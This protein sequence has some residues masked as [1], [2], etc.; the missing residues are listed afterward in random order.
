M[1]IAS[2]YLMFCLVAGSSTA[3]HAEFLDGLEQERI[4]TTSAFVDAPS[5]PEPLLRTVVLPAADVEVAFDAQFFLDM[6]AFET[7]AL[8]AASL[9][10]PPA[11]LAALD[12]ERFVDPYAPVTPLMIAEAFVPDLEATGSV[13][14]HAIWLEN[15]SNEP[16][17]PVVLP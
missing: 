16:W 10:P 14:A 3:V 6:H 12:P 2:A 4:V 5:H 17:E 15:G 9:T 8:I 13:P 11:A 7:A 1:R